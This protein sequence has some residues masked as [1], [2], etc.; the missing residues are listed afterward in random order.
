M[1]GREDRALLETGRSDGL[2]RALPE[3]SRTDRADLTL[4]YVEAKRDL[5]DEQTK[6]QY[7][8]A[9]RTARAE[10]TEARAEEKSVQG[11]RDRTR[12]RDDGHEL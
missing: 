7:D 1:T 8:R 11:A 2:R 6:G 12:D 9:L 10:R 5:A 4:T 3:V